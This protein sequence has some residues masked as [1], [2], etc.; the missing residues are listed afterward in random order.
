MRLVRVLAFGIIQYFFVHLYIL[1]LLDISSVCV[2]P[3]HVIFAYPT[4]I[5][6]VAPILMQMVNGKEK[7]LYIVDGSVI[8]YMERKVYVAVTSKNKRSETPHY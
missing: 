3:I 8:I 1:A 5:V 6:C 7:A 4:H 2:A